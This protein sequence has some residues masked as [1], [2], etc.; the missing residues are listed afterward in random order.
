MR[1]FFLGFALLIVVVV[2]MAGFRGEMS[3]KPPIEVFPDMDR[4]AKLRPQEPNSF[5]PSGK[6]SQLPVAG[7][8]ARDQPLPGISHPVTGG[9]VFPFDEVP[10]TTGRMLTSTNF[11]EVNPYPITPEFIERG[12]ER[13]TINCSPCHGA[14]G[15]GKGI[16]TQFGMA[17]VANLHDKRIV[18]MPDGEI[19]NTIT[20]GKNLMGPYGPHVE[21]RD[22]W[23][24]IAYLRA[25]QLTQLARPDD[26]PESERANLIQSQSNE[27]QTYE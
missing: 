2:S 17:V 7:T 4:Q 15:D 23:A 6:S 9:K 12:R 25:L 19:F 14:L 13:F 8:I 21:I 22:R 10:A 18:D 11:V 27:S 3:R 26:L 20:H 24:I 1:Y 5:F 16:T